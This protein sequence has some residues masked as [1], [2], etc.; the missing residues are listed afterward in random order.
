MKQ[1]AFEA[2]V[3]GGGPAGLTAALAL[4]DAGIETAMIDPAPD[5]RPPAGRTTAIMAPQAAFLQELAAWPADG[6]AVLA[7]LRIVNRPARGPSSD[8][9][10]RSRELGI[11]QFGW[12]VANVALVEA[13]A[14]RVRYSV[15]TIAAKLAG[16]ERHTGRWLLTLDDGV[17]IT[18]PLVVGADGKG[19]KV[20]QTLGINIRRHDYGQM[21]NT[22]LLEHAGDAGDVSTELHKPG[23]PFTTVPAGARRSSLVWLEPEPTANTIGALDDAGFA[24]AVDEF[25]A[26]RLGPVSAVHGRGLMPV[27]GTL[28]GR[29]VAPGALILG[30]AAHSVSPLGAQ[31]FNLTVRD[32]RALHEAARRAG[33][34]AALARSESLLRYERARLTETRAVFWLIDT[35]NRAV[36]R[37]DPALGVARGLGLEAVARLQPVRQQLMQRLLQ[38]NPLALPAS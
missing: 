9:L 1:R 18:T 17:V 3:I 4:A 2:V 15:T 21:A 20:R 19:S 14:V 13:L 22:A 34:G 25:S 7:G 29:L 5:A 26:D 36:L 32:C 38:T 11:A 31:G 27:V 12:N 37:A 30:E 35:L 8:V 10:F 28:A 16:M 33:S 24:A 6:T 23:G